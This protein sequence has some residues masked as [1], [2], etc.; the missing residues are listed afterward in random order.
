[1]NS[2][3]DILRIKKI[4]IV[5]IVIL[6]LLIVV[7]NINAQN[8]C[9]NVGFE[10]GNFNGWVAETGYSTGIT[11]TV[12]VM[13]NNGVVNGRH[14]IVTG[15]NDAVLAFAG[16]TLPRLAPGGGN[17]S[18]KL[19]NENVGAEAERLTYRFPVTAENSVLIYQY[20]V[21]LND[22]GHL[23]RPIFNISLRTS[24]GVAV[25]CGNFNVQAGP[26]IPGFNYVTINNYPS[27]PLNV[28][29][30]NWTSVPVDL[31]N[32]IG[33]T[34]IVEFTTADCTA[35]EHFGYAYVDAYCSKMEIEANYCS[36][37]TF[38][39]FIAPPGYL[40]YQW[41]N[42]QIGQIINVQNP[43]QYDSLL[44]FMT[45]QEGCDLSLVV[46]LDT[47][48][49][50]IADFIHTDG[51]ANDTIVFSSTSYMIGNG[52]I[53]EYMWIFNNQDTVIAQ[54]PLHVFHQYGN[55]TATLIVTSSQGCKDTITQT[56]FLTACPCTTTVPNIHISQPLCHNSNAVVECI[57]NYSSQ[58]IYHWNFGSFNNISGSNQGPYVITY[59][60]GTS[61][62]II[63]LW[64]TDFDTLGNACAEAYAIDTIIFPTPVG[65]MIHSANAT[66]FG[67]NT[68][69]ATVT[70]LGGTPPYSYLWSDNAQ[71]TTATAVNLPAGS[72]YVTITDQHQC[73]RID[74]AYIDQPSAI[75]ATL[76]ANFITCYGANTGNIQLSVNGGSPPYSYHWSNGQLVQ[77]P[78][79]LTSG[80]YYVTIT[81]A[82][83][84]TSVF[85]TF[86]NQA[87]EIQGQ[88]S[89]IEP[90][91]HNGN[92]GEAFVEVSGGTPPYTYFWNSVQEGMHITGL[93]AGF[94]SVTVTDNNGCIRS[95]SSYM[96]D[97]APVVV[98]LPP[99]FTTCKNQPTIITAS[100][101]GGTAPYVFTWNNGATGPSISI[102]PNQTEYYSV[103]ATDSHNCT[104]NVSQISVNVFPDVQI[105]AI[106]DSLKICLGDSVQIFLQISGGREPYTVLFDGYAPPSPFFVKPTFSGYHSLTVTDAC[107]S[108]DTDWVYIGV[109][110][111]PLVS[112]QADK[113][114]GC[115]PLT[116]QFNEILS[117]STCTHVW[118][119]DDIDDNNLSLSRNPV[120]VFEF[121][122]TYDIS[123]EVTNSFGC[124]SALTIPQMI[125]VYPK[126]N[127]LFTTDKI[128]V[129]VTNTVVMFYNQSTGSTNYFWS[130][131]DGDSS[132][133]KN[134]IHLFPSIASEYNVYLVATNEY[135][136]K[137]TS[138]QKIVVKGEYTFY[139][140]TAFSPNN[141]GVN[142]FFYVFGEGI[143]DKDFSLFIYD[144][145]G[146]KIFE[147]NDIHQGW[148]GRVKNRDFVPL[149]VY[150]WLAR[151]RDLHNNLHEVSGKVTVIK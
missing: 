151:F 109:V 57:S 91:C 124:K 23:G 27:G 102:N 43:E 31:H 128:I 75:S 28:I 108:V 61:Q 81:D 3:N 58:A 76:T 131:G 37:D 105:N 139:A 136:C 107:G 87:T 15:G 55:N 18:V 106:Q 25:P 16:I 90:R 82:N 110:Q 126:P 26:G 94:Y 118:N 85:S 50:P 6:L 14:T 56:F 89:F 117:D 95:F 112:I 78:Q 84:C 111:P 72:Y 133:L 54:N 7:N 30:K 13:Y 52:N 17:Y 62:Q 145:W 34:I 47:I 35:G 135:G 115:P 122:G 134:P 129:S 127:S 80:W 121:S 51:C 144:R 67:S 149:G 113:T 97:P 114:Q 92:D 93:A 120:H 70:A 8:N 147:C 140:P 32:Y 138:W 73:S 123:C 2:E 83:Q 141:D 48:P 4:T 142:D 40:Y 49:R 45:P 100:A 29:Y 98:S 71:Q 10:Y 99:S 74:S 143:S 36:G 20:A 103:F 125:T 96:N 24:S 116:V 38:A 77:N 19:G 59:P 79:N 64:V 63:E 39:Q 1:M 68:G 42:G 60:Q 137:D 46:H 12:P 11:T 53:V 101:T 69:S 86:I 44:V 5:L 150:T 132:L 104:S 9:Y 66:C 148:D 88:I 130:F 22:P 65:S 146:E 33:D 21:V 119:F 41:S